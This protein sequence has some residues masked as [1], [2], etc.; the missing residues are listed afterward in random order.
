MSCLTDAQIQSIADGEAVVNGNEGDG[1][2]AHL[3]SCPRCSARVRERENVMQA[4]GEA[5]RVPE[6]LPP[7][8]SLRI[9]R[10]L[11]DGSASGATRLR[12]SR[13]APAWPRAGR[14][15]WSAGAVAVAT[16]LAVVFVAPIVRGPATVSAA[17]ILAR[18]ANQ[19]A[20][21][22]TTGIEVLEYDLELDGVPREMMPDHADGLYRVKQIVDH[23]ANGRYLLATH[24]PDGRL[25]SA[26]AQDPATRRRVVALL[27]DDQP[28]RFGFSVPDSVALSLPEIERLHMQASVAMMQTS[29]DK[30]LQVLDTPAGR[31]YRIQ[32]PQV[33]AQTPTAVW[34]LS[35]AEVVIDASDYH[36]VEFAVKGTFMKQPYSVSYRLIARSVDAQ[37]PADAFEVPRDPR[38]IE[39]DGEGSAIPARDVL[40]ASL[41]EYARIKRDARQ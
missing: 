2:R 25:L 37:V 34:D 22:V 31:Q 19:L 29:G 35:Q 3:A 8:T 13:V 12:E 26:V 20:A 41:R 18:S 36:V 27:I 17:E 5:M 1:I 33:S 39:I 28:Y 24:G 23:D 4:I 6:A 9:E 16:L 21:R 11:A 7:G 32:V 10:A 30:H 14:M 40:V 38:A 15:I